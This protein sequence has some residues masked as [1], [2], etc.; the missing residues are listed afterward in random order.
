LLRLLYAMTTREI[1]RSLH[2]DARR[3]QCFIGVAISVTH[4]LALQE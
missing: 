4:D 2:C 1:M 3:C